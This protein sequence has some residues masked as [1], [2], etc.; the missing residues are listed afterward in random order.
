ME[1]VAE[2]EGVRVGKSLWGSAPG[3]CRGAACERE[4]L[5]V[6]GAGAVRMA[7]LERREW[8]SSV[9]EVEGA[10]LVCPGRK[11]EAVVLELLLVLLLLLP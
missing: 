2:V 4:R 1:A 3:V 10:G 5:L 6:L 7:C 11:A 8:A 9:L